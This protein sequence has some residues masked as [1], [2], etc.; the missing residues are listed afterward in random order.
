MF[1]TF[2]YTYD[3]NGNRI[4]QADPSG[5]TTSGYDALNRLIQATYPAT[6]GTWSWAY[7]AVG[8]RTSQT[9]PSGTTSYTYDA[10]NRLTQA[11]VIVYSYDANGNLTTTS[12][13]QTFTW[14]PFNRLTQASGPGGAVTYT[15][16]GDGLKVHRSGPDGATRYYYDGIRPIWETDSGGALKAELDRDV[17][18]NL[19][20]RREPS[21]AR[22][23]F[24]H[25]GL[26][27]PS[28]V[29]DEAAS[30]VASLLYDAW[31]NVRSS[32]GAWA[33]ENY[34]FTGAELDRATGLYHMGARFYD[35]AIGRWLSEDPEEH[36]YFEPAS[37]NFYAYV[38][39]NPTNLVDPDGRIAVP[40]SVRINDLDLLFFAGTAAGIR[41][42]IAIGRAGVAAVAKILIERISWNNDLMFQIPRKAQDTPFG[43]RF[44]D[45]AIYRGNQIIEGIEIKAGDLRLTEFVR[46]QIRADAW[47][48][49]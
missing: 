34:R 18:G 17:F 1:Q 31:G 7:D 26:F 38:N 14:D 19:L 12:A 15:Y 23:Y 41:S 44:W 30:V 3:P 13:G 32:S 6:Y 2:S 25:D 29:T 16:N 4:T 9:A 49:K 33:A 47:L 45:L 27:G 10:N 48:I 28:G 40:P 36:G 43:K 35:P 11:G 5:T 22:R 46:R 24:T 42:A 39:S 21:G 37:L 8:N 20:S